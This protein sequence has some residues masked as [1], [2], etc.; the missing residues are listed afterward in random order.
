MEHSALIRRSGKVDSFGQPC[1]K[2][3][4]TSSED[5]KHVKGMGISVQ[6][7]SCHSPTTSRLNSSM[8]EESIKWDL[9]Q[10]RRAMSTS[11]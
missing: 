8:S 5:V 11:W 6:V 7:T 3:Q 9:F 1:M 2:T 4:R 10:S